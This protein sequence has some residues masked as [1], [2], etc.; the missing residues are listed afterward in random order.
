[1]NELKAMLDNKIET[2]EF[3]TI[4]FPKVSDLM[5]F[6]DSKKSIEEQYYSMLTPFRLT[7]DILNIDAETKKKF[8][9][10]DLL[11]INFLDEN[12]KKTTYL[13]QF[14][15]SLEFF[16]KLR[17]VYDV[18][19]KDDNED[20]LQV[21]FIGEHFIDRDNFD[22]LCE[23]IFG[24]C[25]TSKIEIEKP[26]ELEN[27][28][29]RDVY[30]KSMEGRNRKSQGKFLSFIEIARCVG[31]GEGTIIPYAQ[32]IQMTVRELFDRYYTTLIKDSWHIN[33]NQCLA[34][35]DSKSLDL[36]HWLIGFKNIYNKD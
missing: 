18:S 19:L 5:D 16:F 26:I 12:G 7:I 6:D 14:M 8:K 23:Y 24:I 15:D 30:K 21:V 13:N 22:S 32:I 28:R 20:I 11:F 33:L 4:Y 17:P 34:G 25:N 35:V 1:M 10:F 2:N 9:R 29:Q 27:D 31:D 36:T 3:G